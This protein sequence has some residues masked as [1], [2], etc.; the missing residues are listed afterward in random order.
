MELFAGVAAKEALRFPV[1]IIACGGSGEMG[2]RTKS[3]GLG[4]GID[5]PPAQP[6]LV[7]FFDPNF[8]TKFKNNSNCGGQQCPP[9]TTAS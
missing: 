8:K 3:R 4:G 2:V 9:Y 1:E 5:F 7:D 6:G